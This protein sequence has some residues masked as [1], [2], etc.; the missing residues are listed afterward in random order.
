MKKVLKLIYTKKLFF[1][2]I[3]IFLYVINILIKTL[4]KHYISYQHFLIY[5]GLIIAFIGEVYQ[6]ITYFYPIN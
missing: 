3:N 4:Y 5:E 2:T 1:Q 6:I